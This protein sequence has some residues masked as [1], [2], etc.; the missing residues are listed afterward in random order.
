MT[1]HILMTDNLTFDSLRSFVVVDYYTLYSLLQI[2]VVEIVE[3]HQMPVSTKNE[4]F[5]S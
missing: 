3:G 5:I 4:H 2:E 1:D